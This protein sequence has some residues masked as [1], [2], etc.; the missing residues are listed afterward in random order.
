MAHVFMAVLTSGLFDRLRINFLSSVH[1]HTRPQSGRVPH[2][3]DSALCAL[4]LN[5]VRLQSSNAIAGLGTQLR[6]QAYYKTVVRMRRTARLVLVLRQPR[7][8]KVGTE[9]NGPFGKRKGNGTRR[10]APF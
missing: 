3:E 7:K 1:T 9:L 10:V 6:Q 8:P 4:A 2:H 5:G